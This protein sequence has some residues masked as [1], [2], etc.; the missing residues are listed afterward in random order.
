MER[1][2]SLEWSPFLISPKRNCRT[3]RGLAE[4]KR[5]RE[6]EQGWAGEGDGCEE[7]KCTRGKG[8]EWWRERERGECND[9][10]IWVQQHRRL[11]LWIV[12]DVLAAERLF[13]ARSWKCSLKVWKRK[14]NFFSDGVFIQDKLWTTGFSVQLNIVLMKQPASYSYEHS[15]NALTCCNIL[16]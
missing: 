3:L 14:K 16:L 7:K 9:W 6:T 2:I 5:E 13:R 12:V 4:R 1:F 10:I 8:R 15:H 11:L